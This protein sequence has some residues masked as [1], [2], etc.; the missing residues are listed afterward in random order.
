MTIHLPRLL[1]CL[2]G[3]LMIYF[4]HYLIYLYEFL[5]LTFFINFLLI[6]MSFEVHVSR[7]FIQ[8]MSVQSHVTLLR[9]IQEMHGLP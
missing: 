8:S 3:V 5:Y 2:N 6:D 4:F 7:G 1:Y 9:A